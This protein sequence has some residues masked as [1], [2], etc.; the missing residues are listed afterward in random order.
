M[1]SFKGMVEM[2]MTSYGMFRGRIWVNKGGTKVEREK[3]IKVVNHVN[4]LLV[5]SL[6]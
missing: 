5:T 4:R 6:A 3:S 2:S 1:G